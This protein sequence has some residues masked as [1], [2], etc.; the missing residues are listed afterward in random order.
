MPVF[1][2][3]F[4]IY[5][6]LVT[7]AFRNDLSCLSAY[8]SYSCKCHCPPLLWLFTIS[9]ADPIK[10]GFATDFINSSTANRFC[11]LNIYFLFSK[12]TFRAVDKY[13]ETSS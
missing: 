8:T 2:H 11:A 9:K 1:V 6:C 12:P 4:K 7:I 3:L 10:I 13:V 5:Y